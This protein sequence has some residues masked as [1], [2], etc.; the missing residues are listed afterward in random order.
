M[1]NVNPSYGNTVNNIPVLDVKSLMQLVQRHSVKC[2]W[3]QSM[4]C[5]CIDPKTG[6]PK[7][8]CKVCHGQGIVFYNSNTIDISVYSDMKKEITSN[9]GISTLPETYATIQL[10]SGG[11][12]QG[13]KIGDRITID[14]WE[15]PENYLFN[16][17]DF[18]LNS[19][20]F[21]PYKF[22]K[23][24]DAFCIEDGNLK[25]IDIDSAFD[26]TDNFIKIKDI[27]LLNKN[28]SINVA[29]IKRFYITSLQKEL[30]Y[31]KYIKQKDK[32]WATGLGNSYLTYGDI[33]NNGTV[34]PGEFVLKM[35]PK[36]T[37]RRENLYF[38]DIDIVSS[39]TDNNRVIS[40]PRVVEMNDILGG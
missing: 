8:N 10:T 12:E 15:T 35:F 33:I 13:V 17:T 40:D 2:T 36:V 37:L 27:S 32:D 4:K 19:G 30:R 6:Q 38:S 39:E 34:A 9:T 16:I 24:N 25:K 31:Q 23:I 20:V 18:R 26:I 3:E 7:P 21:V 29:A 22:S 1:V 11:I 28:I 5:P 14:G